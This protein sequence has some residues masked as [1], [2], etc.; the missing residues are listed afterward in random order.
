MLSVLE[1][2]K[3]P[4]HMTKAPLGSAQKAEMAATGRVEL[5][6][7]YDDGPYIITEKLIK[8]GRTQLVL[9]DPLDLPFPVRLLHGTADVDVALSVPLRIVEHVTCADL[10]LTLVKGADHRFSEEVCLRMIVD[11][12]EEVSR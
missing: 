8:D 5:P 10:R 12:V 1:W 4:S 11:A 6:S 7:D 2:R 9:R 3:T